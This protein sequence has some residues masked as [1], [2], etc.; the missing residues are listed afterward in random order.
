MYAICPARQLAI[1][2]GKLAVNA[3]LAKLSLGYVKGEYSTM[4]FVAHL[5]YPPAYEHAV[6]T[7]RLVSLRYAL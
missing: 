5:K 3:P 1:A 4:G 7:A 6:F 2:N